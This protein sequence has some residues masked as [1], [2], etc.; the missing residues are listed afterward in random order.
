M[1]RGGRVPLTHLCLHCLGPGCL[2]QGLGPAQV[3]Q[4]LAQLALQPPAALSFRSSFLS[5]GAG[6]GQAMGE[7]L[8]VGM[9]GAQ[10]CARRG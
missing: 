5:V 9:R 2:L 6:G 8:G 3:L 10:R 4:G 7:G 1:R